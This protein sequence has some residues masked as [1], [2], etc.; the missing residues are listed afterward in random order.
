M[1]MKTRYKFVA[2]AA[3]AASLVGLGKCAVDNHWIPETAFMKAA[4]PKKVDIPI[5]HV[6]QGAPTETYSLA[7]TPVS[8]PGLGTL[9][10]MSIPWNA[11]GSF[12]LANG[13]ETTRTDS[14]ISQFTGGTMRI[15]RQDDYSVMQDAMLKFAQANEKG[16]GDPTQ[17]AAFVQIM[18]DA[19]SSYL[20]VNKQLAKYHQ[21]VAA[22]AITGFSYG[23]DKC[24]MSIGVR[25]DPQ[26]A[27]G[28]VV[29]AVPRD[30]DQNACIKW[31]SD[32]GIKIN[33]D[34]STFDRDA[35]NFADYGSF[36]DADEAFIHHASSIRTVVK[37]GLKTAEKVTVSVD[38]V[39]TWTPGD[40][41][42][43]KSP[44]GPEVETVASTLDYN[45]QM[46]AIMI[47]NVQWMRKHPDYVVGMVKAI[48]RASFQIR[49]DENSLMKMSVINAAVFGKGGGEEAT[50]EYWAEHFR[51]TTLRVGSRNVPVG[52]SR[53]VTL[54]E[55][56]DYLGL[57][58]GSYPIYKGVYNYFGDVYHTYYPTFVPDYPKYEDAV[59]TSYIK[60]ALSGVTLG[61]ATTQF[62]QAKPITTAVSNRSYP[63]VVFDTGKATLRPES[64]RALIK[65]ADQSS[66]TGLR[67]RIV[68]HTDNV[69][70]PIANIKLSRARAQAVAD[71][72]YEMAPT[73][74]PR[75]RMEV[76]GVGD[77]ETV[78]DNATEAGRQKN[79]RVEFILGS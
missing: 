41:V 4:V 66:M 37:D 31:A 73:T 29:S 34:T 21:T 10:V 76:A 48:D 72:L 11:T 19:L 45:L 64:L 78:A 77:T 15:E 46:P 70:Q 9:R 74:F 58:P 69:G 50:P 53:V 17:G 38:G 35:L 67:I 59:D 44:R 2:G 68:G 62:A 36:G 47:G 42:V 33:V 30:G 43:F 12:S 16:D 24:I 57:R 22:F 55:V 7:A 8:N 61:A 13:G 27:K 6:A 71:A 52:G 39:A 60:Q 25:A 23:E 40:V 79:R 1:G 75:E 54:A 56:A 28:L 65:M 51:G 14:L 18:G 26:K 3:I 32:N 5:A 63:D 49:S 20:Q